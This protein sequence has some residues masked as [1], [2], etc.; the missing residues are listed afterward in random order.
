MTIALT[1]AKDSA[2]LTWSFRSLALSAPSA[3]SQAAS[4]SSPWTSLSIED[5]DALIRR[6]IGFIERR[7][8]QRE[9]RVES[10]RDTRDFLRL[11]LAHE[12]NEV[13]SVLFLDAQNRVI[14]YQPM[15]FGSI[16]Q[17]SVY[18]RVVVKR[19]LELNAAAVILAHNHPSGLVE[20]SRADELLTQTLKSALAQVDVRVLD[21]IIVGEGAP[22]SFAER[23]LL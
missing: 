16:T 15:F 14:S 18:P 10:P 8:F 13:F 12:P 3:T 22:C 17:T 9:Y 21:H 2:A 19:A 20:P 23:G 6:A 1:P 5:E 4:M 11:K 7:C